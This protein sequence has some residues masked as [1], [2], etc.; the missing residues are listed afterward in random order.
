M[1]G[2]LDLIHIINL[3]SLS[4]IKRITDSPH[5]SECTKYYLNNVYNI[6]GECISL[7]RTYNCDIGMSISKISYMINNDFSLSC[8]DSNH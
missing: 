6:S 5:I 7:F 1:L 3:R 2:R 8:D 4:F